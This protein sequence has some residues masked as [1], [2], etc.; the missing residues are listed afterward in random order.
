MSSVAYFSYSGEIY[1]QR[2]GMAMGSPWSHLDAIC[3]WNG[4]SKKAIS[5]SPITCR[6]RLWKRYV[7]DVLEVIRKGEVDRLTD[8]LNQTYPSNSIKFTYE[9]EKDGAIPFLDSDHSQTWRFCKIVY[10]QKKKAH[11]DQYLQFSSHHPLHRKL[12]V[13]RTLLDRNDSIVA[14]EED[15]KLE[16]DH[17]RKALSVCGYPEWTIN[18]VKKDRSR[19]KPNPATSKKF[20]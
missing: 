16:E 18:K 20:H 9:Q 8:H 5:T 3:S 7:D 14:E 12:G 2:F 6:L 13:I 11:T 19:P 4:L 1:R 17:I 15:R 10:L